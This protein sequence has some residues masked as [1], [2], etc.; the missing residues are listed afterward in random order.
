MPF[1]NP[2]AVTETEPVNPLCAVM[3]TVTG[4]VVP[5]T[6]VDTEVGATLMVKSPALGGWEDEP[7]H[8]MREHEDTA[9]KSRIMRFI[10][11]SKKHIS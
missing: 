10:V 6:C 3:M 5:P 8:D 11:I 7:P 1:G 9:V 4:L 2:L